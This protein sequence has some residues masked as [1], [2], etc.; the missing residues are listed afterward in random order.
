MMKLK[1]AKI[2]GSLVHTIVYPPKHHVDIDR[3][4]SSLV[5]CGMR[6]TKGHS[7]QW[8]TSCP[9]DKIYLL[10]NNEQMTTIILK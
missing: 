3:I 2:S 5:S 6:K 4:L 10:H 1:K 9:M 7:K 8:S